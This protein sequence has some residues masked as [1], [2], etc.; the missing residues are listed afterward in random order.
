LS[1]HIEK[2]YFEDKKLDYSSYQ[3]LMKDLGE[4]VDLPKDEDAPTVIQHVK[5]LNK[6]GHKHLVLVVGSDRVEDMQKLLDKYNGTEFKFKKIDVVSA[7]Q[8]DMDAD[9]EEEDEKPG[10]DETPEQKK[11]REEKKR[12]NMSATKMRGHAISGRYSEF[13]AGMHPE[14]DEEHA[15]EMYQEVRQGM[16]IK[17]GPDTPIRALV[18]HAKR[19][20]PIGVKARRE[21]KRREI[22]K[23]QEINS[24]QAKKPVKPKVA[25]F[26]QFSPTKKITKT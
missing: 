25:G 1:T 14:A 7:G 23:Q 21:M 6:K 5:N 22:V 19:K 12:R 11:A 8:R 24:K 9:V 3:K 10:K 4:Y 2:N 17:I 13:K 15:R 26:K 18:N 16:D 20:D